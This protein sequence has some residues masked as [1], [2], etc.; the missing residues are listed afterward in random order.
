MHFPRSIIEHNRIQ[1]P[2]EDALDQRNAVQIRAWSGTAPGSPP[3]PPAASPTEWVIV[4]DNVISQDNA[5]EII[6]TCQTNN[7]IDA[8][9]APD[10]RNVVFERNFMFISAAGTGGPGRLSR[11]F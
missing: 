3:V 4:S 7:C 2:Q 6:R 1:R 11:V 8:T 10:V 9:G 5:G